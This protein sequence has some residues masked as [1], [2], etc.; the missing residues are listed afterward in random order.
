MEL[1]YIRYVPKN[2]TY[3]LLDLGKRNS[4]ICGL[5]SEKVNDGERQRIL[6]STK[7]LDAL[8]LPRKLQWLRDHC[9]QAFKTAYREIKVANAQILSHHKIN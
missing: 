7:V 5:L 1:M 9:P 3:L 6:S 8:S 2:A 4:K